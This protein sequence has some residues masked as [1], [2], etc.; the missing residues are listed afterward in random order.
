MT[1][2]NMFKGLLLMAC[3]LFAGITHAQQETQ[4]FQSDEEFAH[5]VEL[6]VLCANAP[7]QNDVTL[8]KVLE[9]TPQFEARM[10]EMGFSVDMEVFEPEEGIRGPYEGVIRIAREP[11]IMVYGH[12]LNQI[13]IYADSGKVFSARLHASPQALLHVV[14]ENGRALYPRVVDAEQAAQG[15][16]YAFSVEEPQVV[17]HGIPAISPQV[18]EIRATEQHMV[19]TIGC[20]DMD[21]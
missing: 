15:I 3:M 6:R 7:D 17:A 16:V 8:D 12:R 13:D 18:I 10:R 5:W 19:S 11:A 14:Q 1:G 9:N 21:F 4:V 20:Y 2:M